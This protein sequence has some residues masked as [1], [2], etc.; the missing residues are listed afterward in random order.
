VDTVGLQ[1]DPDMGLAAFQPTGSHR[2]KR[3][4]SRGE[5]PSLAQKR[6]PERTLAG[7]IVGRAAAREQRAAELLEK[8]GAVVNIGPAHALVTG[9]APH[10]VDTEQRTCD[11]ADARSGRVCAHIL[12]AQ[13]AANG[14]LPNGIVTTSALLGPH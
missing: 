12:A 3:L 7:E 11:C 9:A 14:S 5:A 4:A 6:R 2:T 1:Q 13:Q 8:P 10:V